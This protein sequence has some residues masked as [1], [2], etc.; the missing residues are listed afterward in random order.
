MS[1]RHGQ[2]KTRLYGIFNGMKQRCYN[3]KHPSYEYYGA[4]GITICDEWLND[5]M[6]FKEWAESHGYTD[7]LTIDRIDPKKG[8]SPDNCQ[9]L[10]INEN[11]SKAKY[12]RTRD[13][14]KKAQE[15]FKGYWRAESERRE[16]N[17]RIK[18]ID[19]IIKLLPDLNWRQL[20]IVKD[21]IN[22]VV[23]QENAY[24]RI[25]GEDKK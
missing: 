3:A 8:Y 17:K 14:Y 21:C 10:T 11:A 13:S 19:E 24:I 25:H 22:W 16:A 6:S 9:W 7:E 18:E 5:F 2:S 1:Q 23:A 12:S 4:K 20:E 15:G